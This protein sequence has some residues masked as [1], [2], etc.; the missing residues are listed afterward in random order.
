MLWMGALLAIPV[1]AWGGRLAA[2][3][4]AGFRRRRG[5]I[6]P[7]GRERV[8][9]A[10]EGAY[11]PPRGHVWSWYRW[12]LWERH[13]TPELFDGDRHGRPD[14]INLDSPSTYSFRYAVL[15]LAISI[16]TALISIV[17]GLL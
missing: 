5:F 1:L 17:A 4:T 12:P 2:E 8:L 7:P 14:N 15:A 11:R 10:V 9:T 16:A 13:T 3:L 6:W